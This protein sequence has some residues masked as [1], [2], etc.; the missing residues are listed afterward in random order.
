M[1]RTTLGSSVRA[2]ATLLPGCFDLTPEYAFIEDGDVTIEP[3][4]G[5]QFREATEYGDLY[6]ISM[7][8]SRWSG[9]RSA[10]RTRRRC[11]TTPPAIRAPARVD[12]H[13]VSA[14]Q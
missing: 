2:A 14:K 13:G 9:A 1:T 11:R 6:A 5:A 7:Q 4:R 3:V 8:S 12:G 10:R